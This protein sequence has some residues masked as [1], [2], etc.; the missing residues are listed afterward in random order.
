MPKVPFEVNMVFVIP[1]EF[2]ALEI[3]VADLNAGAARAVFDKTVTLGE[4][5]KPLYINGHLDSAPVGR[6][7]VEGGASVNILPLLMFKKLGHTDR[8]LKQTNM[9]LSGFSGEPAEVKGIVS[10]ELTVGS[11]TM[12]IAFF[13]VDVKGRY[14]MLLKHNWIHTNSCVP[15]MLHQCVIQWVGDNV[16][17][18]K[19]DEMA[20]VA[21][22]DSQMDVQGWRMRCLTRWDLTEYDYISMGKDEFVSISEKPTTNTT[23]LSDNVL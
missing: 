2:Q 18:I 4:H 8:D 7:M 9:S 1:G 13:I 23:Q 21:V 3:E 14:N 19:V 5:T 11:K 17:V 15:S 10:K 6:M 22:T 12:P 20:C 16:E